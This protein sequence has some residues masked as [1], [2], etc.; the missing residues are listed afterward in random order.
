MTMMIAV[1]TPMYMLLS[2][3]RWSLRFYPLDHG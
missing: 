3:G 1:P 2:S